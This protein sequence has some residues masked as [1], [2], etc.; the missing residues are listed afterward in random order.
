VVRS[1]AGKMNKLLAS[2]SSSQ[3]GKEELGDFNLTI[4]GTWPKLLVGHVEKKKVWGVN[5]S[6]LTCWGGG[7]LSYSRQDALSTNGDGG[8]REKEE[9]L[10]YAVSPFP[11]G[12]PN[13][14]GLT[15]MIR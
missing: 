15:R 13:T 12:T 5:V 1:L 8:K 10:G 9:L 4:S 6:D 3:G 2:G 11:E 14:M 7:E